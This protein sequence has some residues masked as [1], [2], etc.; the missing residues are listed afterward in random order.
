M[1]KIDQA[2]GSSKEDAPCVAKRR[3]GL[4]ALFE[5]IEGLKSELKKVSWTTGVELRLSTKIVILSIFAFGFGIYVVDLFIK[6]VLDGAASLMRLL[7]G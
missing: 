1:V 2:D 6:G 5:R 7:L 4:R 3:W